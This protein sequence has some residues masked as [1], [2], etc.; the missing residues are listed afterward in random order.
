MRKAVK[1]QKIHTIKAGKITV[2]PYW[3]RVFNSRYNSEAGLFE[4]NIRGNP[5]QLIDLDDCGL[6]MAREIFGAAVEHLQGRQKEAYILHMR[7]KKSLDE[8]ATILSISKSSAQ[9]YLTRAIKFISVYC[10]QAIEKEQI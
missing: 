2:S 7:E 4:E 1:I 3:D 10:H 5:D 9:V 6:S 8:V